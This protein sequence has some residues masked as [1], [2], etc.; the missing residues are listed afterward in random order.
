MIPGPSELRPNTKTTDDGVRQ[1]NN[2]KHKIERNNMSDLNITTVTGRLVKDPILRNAETGNLWGVFTLASNYHYKDKS[3]EFREEA[4]FI[5][6]KAFGRL[7]ELLAKHKKRE[8]AIASG[9]L[10]TESW[11]KDGRPHSQL[12]LICDTLRFFLPQN[13]TATPASAGN[14]E[15]LAGE[16]LEGKEGTPPF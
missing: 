7:A 9:R 8:M 3:G 10:R 6:C 4:A 13:G 1:D 5:P 2:N 16:E 15:A 11:E 12:T 14:S